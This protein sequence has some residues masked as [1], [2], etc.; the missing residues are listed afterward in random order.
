MLN[1]R[2]LCNQGPQSSRQPRQHIQLTF[3]FCLSRVQVLSLI[4]LLF[5]SSLF[6]LH[7]LVLG[8]GEGLQMRRQPTC[9]TSCFGFKCRPKGYYIYG[10]RRP[11]CGWPLHFW[12]WIIMA[13]TSWPFDTAPTHAHMALSL[14]F[15]STALST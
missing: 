9:V 7:V 2:R 6:W 15:E 8:L 10:I 13:L 11:F 3:A 1:E 4:L 12:P 14:S 5:R